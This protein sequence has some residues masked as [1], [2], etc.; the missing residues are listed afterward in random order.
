[1]ATPNEIIDHWKIFIEKEKEENIL[2]AMVL[3]LE[4]EQQEYEEVVSTY[5]NLIEEVN[6]KLGRLK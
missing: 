6:R 3:D 4:A 1:M 5:D 2:S